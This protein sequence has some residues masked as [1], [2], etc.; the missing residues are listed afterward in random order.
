MGSVQGN[1]QAV[2]GVANRLR[3]VPTPTSRFFTTSLGRGFDS[4]VKIFEYL[5]QTFQ[6][7]PNV[8]GTIMLYSERAVCPSCIS[9]MNQFMEMYP[10]I[11]IT[12]TSG[13]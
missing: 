9:V 4:E 8:S 6:N 13:P 12:I 7:N 2:S 11:V 3:T 1:L 10:N 5:A